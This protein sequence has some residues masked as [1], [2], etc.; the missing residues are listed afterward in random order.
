MEPKDP[1]G[2]ASRGVGGVILVVGRSLRVEEDEVGVD[3]W[4]SESL[5]EGIL[6][7]RERGRARMA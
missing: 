1:R 4:E 5:A 3:C 7:V 6:E 2:E